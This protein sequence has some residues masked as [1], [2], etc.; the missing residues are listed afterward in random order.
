MPILYEG[1]LLSPYLNGYLDDDMDMFVSLQDG[2]TLYDGDFRLVKFQPPQI[3]VDFVKQNGLEDRYYAET[4]F[5]L[6][7]E[8]SS[9]GVLNMILTQKLRRDMTWALCSDVEQLQSL[10]FPISDFDRYFSVVDRFKVLS[11][12]T[13]ELDREL[14]QNEEESLLPEVLTLQKQ[15][16]L[17]QLLEER[18]RHLDKMIIFV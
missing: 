1:P 17:N 11:N 3:L 9:W 18:T 12:I 7:A 16:V 10:A 13:F 2:S 8:E 4:P 14:H 6:D 15:V 5:T